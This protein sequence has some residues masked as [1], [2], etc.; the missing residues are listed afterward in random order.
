MNYGLLIATSELQ[1]GSSVRCCMVKVNDLGALVKQL[2]L[3][4]I[5]SLVKS[6]GEK[7]LVSSYGEMAEVNLDNSHI[8]KQSYEESSYCKN[9][10]CAYFKRNGRSAVFYVDSEPHFSMTGDPKNLQ[11]GSVRILDS[12]CRSN[13]LMS[14]NLVQE[15]SKKDCIYMLGKDNVLY[16]FD[17]KDIMAKRTPEVQIV[18]EKAACYFV[19]AASVAVLTTNGVLNVDGL[20]SQTMLADN[21]VK[22]WTAT[23][24]GCKGFWFCAAILDQLTSAIVTIGKDGQQLNVLE[25]AEPLEQVYTPSLDKPL[26]TGIY[27]LHYVPVARSRGVLLAIRRNGAALIISISASGK[28]KV[29][30]KFYLTQRTDPDLARIPISMIQLDSPKR[31]L[32]GGYGWLKL[33]NLIK[34]Y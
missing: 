20:I 4:W 17:W 19:V 13:V 31:I 33:I 24:R 14:H 7:L 15:C 8:S 3:G 29:I 5:Y 22:R 21:N 1:H 18:A 32:V 12:S 6:D 26:D 34:M 11:K 25:V 27:M 30:K 28:T 9:A 10:F 16:R 2:K 23:T